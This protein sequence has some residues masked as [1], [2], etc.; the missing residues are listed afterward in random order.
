MCV[1]TSIRTLE[2]PGHKFQ[3]KAQRV[4]SSLATSSKL[5]VVV[6]IRR[7][8]SV[9]SVSL[10]ILQLHRLALD[11]TR[12]GRYAVVSGGN[13]HFSYPGRDKSLLI[14]VLPSFRSCDELNRI[15]ALLDIII[16]TITIT[17]LLLSIHKAL[18]SD[19]RNCISI[20]CR[21]RAPYPS[22]RLHRCHV[23]YP[24]LPNSRK[25]WKKKALIPHHPRDMIDARRLKMPRRRE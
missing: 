20:C 3:R 9:T 5:S 11:W 8:C 17:Y 16:I 14:S 21:T 10:R 15:G 1:Q 25:P 12:G 24:P 19:S 2:G 13:C 22:P 6:G 7:V 4:E 18:I 23:L